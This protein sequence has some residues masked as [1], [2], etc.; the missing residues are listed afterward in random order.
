MINLKKL[1]SA[2]QFAL[3]VG[4]ASLVSG[5]ALAQ[6]DEDGAEEEATTLDRI[7]VTGSRL[8]RA[9]VEGAMPVI[10]ID[11]EQIDASGDVSV[12]DVLRDTTFASF[13]N[14]RPQ[15]GSSAQSLATIDLRGLGSG[16]T[17][18]LIDGRRAPASAQAASA[19][20]DVNA[21]P[22]AAVE[23]IEIL[24]DGAS[25]IYGS[26]AIGGVVNIILRKDFNG[27]ELRYGIQ[28]TE[29]K[30]GDQ[31]E[32]SVTFGISGDRGSLIGG[33][34]MMDRENV[35]TRDQ[36]GYV[37]GVS[38]YGNNY[39]EWGGGPAGVPGYACN[40][41]GFF[42]LPN[43]LCSY[44]F[45][46]V[47]AN[48]ASINNKSLFLLGDYQINDDWS[49]YSSATVTKTGSF[50]RYAPTP[51]LLIVSDGTPQDINNGL[52]CDE[53]PGNIGGN[54][55]PGSSDGLVTY[56]FHRFAAGG[57]RDNEDTTVN[58]DFLVGFEG[59]LTDTIGVDFGIRR[60][61]YDFKN[62]GNGYVVGSLAR[63]AAENGSYDLR[64]P[65]GASP[66]TLQG[67]T[68]TISRN[69]FFK[70][71]EIFG[72][73]HFDLFEMGGG[74]SNAV[75]GAEYREDDYSDQ[76]DSLSE[77]GVVL[78]S[79]G[80]SAAGDRTVGAAYFEW[81]FPFASTFDITLAGRYDRY[82]DY[83]S[84]FSPKVAMR[85][86]PMDSL[87]LRASYGQGFRAPPLDILTQ[88]T[89][90]S[91]EPVKD[92]Q[93]CLAV[94]APPTCTIQVNTFFIANPDLSSEQSDQYGFGIVW[95]PMDWLDMSAD[96]YHIQ[97][98][99]TISS[100]GAQT[101]INFDLGLIPGEP[102]PGLGVTRNPDNGRV[103]RID[104]GYGNIGDV[105]TDG[106]DVRVNTDFDL[107]GMGRLQNRLTV[108]YINKYE[109]TGISGVTSDSI[110]ILGLP[111]T[112]ANLTNIWSM[113]DWT[114]IFATNYIAGQESGAGQ[115]GGYATN[116]L[117]FAYEAPWNAQIAV[118]ATNVGN[119]LPEL[120]SVGGRPYNYDLY[121]D[122]G[123]TTYFRYTQ[124]F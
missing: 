28:Q 37:Q 56:Y 74:I 8:S 61:E 77:A 64:D 71:N 88:K 99:D 45:N 85:W 79:A 3:F 11:R 124:R 54:C 117:Q 83:G 72:L 94:S 14:F 70:T 32:A 62:L 111:D 31:E 60:T 13:G 58:T 50:G 81:L 84:D 119:R 109:V 63:I 38:I 73:A 115:V 101:L 36:I 52:R 48:Q 95:A 75:V 51:G 9:D 98:E 16:R 65:Y 57:N 93:S 22:L 4:A 19:G 49:V 24:S 66:E 7:Q 17:L 25:A 121:D 33:A 10:V 116:D 41:P 69:S 46:A 107:G 108:S 2:I 90:F 102:P 114:A 59:Q 44:N 105:E 15:S 40:D 87:T 42:R 34:G 53:T 78:G 47:A 97:I 103:T 27:V 112:R 118:G 23:R 80:N 106:V 55:A 18:V 21:I 122:Y 1:P 5:N 68:A 104:A 12:A 91:A 89:T 76:Y 82:S 92:E 29:V 100:V 43:G 39:Y 67:F 35:F 26:D 30:G 120:V 6:D 86:Q 123:R 113:G 96:Y 20:V 110:G